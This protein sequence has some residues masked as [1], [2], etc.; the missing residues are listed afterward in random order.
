MAVNT[1]QAVS[2]S[3][4]VCSVSVHVTLAAL[5]LASARSAVRTAS[6]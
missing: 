1:A 4:A 3:R 6:A 2:L 5:V